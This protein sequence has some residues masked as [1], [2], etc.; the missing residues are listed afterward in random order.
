MSST[1]S[2]CNRS[3]T[4]RHG[5]VSI[6]TLSN[7]HDTVDSSQKNA[8]IHAA[9]HVPEAFSLLVAVEPMV[10]NPAT[11]VHKP[12]KVVELSTTKRVDTFSSK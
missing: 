4:W 5:D 9:L 1:K 3:L 7:C 12:F 10:I 6:L 2:N 11:N 8:S